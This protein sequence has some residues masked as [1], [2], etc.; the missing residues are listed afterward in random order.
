M[1]L[2][3]CYPLKSVESTLPLI[4]DIGYLHLPLFSTLMFTRSLLIL[5]IPRP[6][7]NSICG[8]MDINIVF[9]CFVFCILISLWSVSASSLSWLLSVIFP[10]FFWS[11]MWEG[12]VFGFWDFSFPIRAFTAVRFLLSTGF[13]WHSTDGV[14]WEELLIFSSKQFLISVLISSSSMVHLEVC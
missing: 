9:V 11:F 4:S 3:S 1:P 12:E 13:R 6:Q 7:P 5:L 2:L 14:D 8:H 10:L